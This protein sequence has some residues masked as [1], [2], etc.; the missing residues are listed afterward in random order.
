MLQ[1]SYQILLE[2]FLATP[3]PAEEALLSQELWARREAA[4]LATGGQACELN[5]FSG[6]K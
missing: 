5:G 4:I 6:S 1:A 3:K 2:Q